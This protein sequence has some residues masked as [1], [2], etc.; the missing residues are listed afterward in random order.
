M[1]TRKISDLNLVGAL[2]SG[3]AFEI[4]VDGVTYRCTAQQIYDLVAQL[5]SATGL[6]L[7]GSAAHDARCSGLNAE[8]VSL[9][10]QRD[11][12]EFLRISVLQVLEHGNG[13][14]KLLRR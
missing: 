12:R 7:T 13:L 8:V 6:D 3:A 4:S 14:V 1:A 9:A 2:T 11:R 5:I 10:I